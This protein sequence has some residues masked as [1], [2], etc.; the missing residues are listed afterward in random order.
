MSLRERTRPDLGIIEPCLPSPAKAPPS[1]LGWLHEIKHD[2]FRILAR[3]DDAGVRLI[4]R[5]GNDF[6]SR[7]PF[8]TMAFRKWP[9]FYQITKRP[10]RFFGSII[11]WPVYDPLTGCCR[12]H[13]VA[14]NPSW[15]TSRSLAVSPAQYTSIAD[16]IGGLQGMRALLATVFFGGA[17]LFGTASWAATLEPVTGDL[18]IN[19]GKGFEKVVASKIEAKVGD[20]VMVNSGGIAKVTYADGCQANVKPGAVMTIPKLSPCASGSLAA[21]LTP[22]YKARPA[23]ALPPEAC[24]WWCLAPLGL[25]GLTA[26][27]PQGCT[28]TLHDGCH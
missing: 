18:W 16:V 24:G 4:T 28:E 2:G 26:L 10:G 8:I 14:T 19:H 13:T 23:E 15:I 1:G 25:F 12:K 27:I 21:D 5:A 9:L 20:S 11:C 3:R 17:V 6:S 22:V 7:F